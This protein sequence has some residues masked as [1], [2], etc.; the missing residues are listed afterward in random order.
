MSSHTP[1]PWC[2]YRGSDNHPVDFGLLIV[3]PLLEGGGHGEDILVVP[4]TSPS[5]QDEANV[6]RIVACVNHCSGFA[7]EDIE[8]GLSMREL[9]RQ[10]ALFTEMLLLCKEALATLWMGCTPL[11]LRLKDMVARA[12]GGQS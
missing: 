5:E 11:S 4:E 6:R 12:E 8:A 2:W 1:E 10:H 3:A 9:V 7:I